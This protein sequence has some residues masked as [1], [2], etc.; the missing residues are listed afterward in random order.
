MI[1]RYYDKMDGKGGDHYVHLC[2]VVA[3]V[4]STVGVLMRGVEDS[5]AKKRCR[6]HLAW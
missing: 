5:R 1:S 6:S 4:N 3:D 2:R